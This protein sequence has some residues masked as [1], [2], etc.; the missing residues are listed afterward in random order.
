MFISFSDV[1]VSADALKEFLQFFYFH[2]VALIMENVADVMYLGKK[3]D[4]KEFLLLCSDLLTANI[5]ADNG[6]IALGMA[7]MYDHIYRQYC[8][9]Q[10]FGAVIV[11][12]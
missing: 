5:T 1:D 6:M 4:V 9:H 7:I 2:R 10:I 8:S 12:C 3:Y 11:N